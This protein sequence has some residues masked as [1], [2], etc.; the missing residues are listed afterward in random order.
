MLILWRRIVLCAR[1]FIP[2]QLEEHRPTDRI[3]QNWKF[4]FRFRCAPS[5]RHYFPPPHLPQSLTAMWLDPR[6]HAHLVVVRGWARMQWGMKNKNMVI[7]FVATRWFVACNYARLLF[8]FCRC[9]TQHQRINSRRL[10]EWTAMQNWHCENRLF[11]S[12]NSTHNQSVFPCA[13]HHHHQ[14]LCVWRVFRLMRFNR[15]LW[16]LVWYFNGIPIPIEVNG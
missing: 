3:Q 8:A 14:H 6:L 4:W 5:I 10:G 11:L 1:Q 16:S 12:I 7:W 15:W 9:A 13:V 2:I